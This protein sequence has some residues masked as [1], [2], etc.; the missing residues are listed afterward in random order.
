MDLYLSNVIALTIGSTPA[1]SILCLSFA[2]EGIRTGSIARPPIDG[3]PC[4][5]VP[6]PSSVIGFG[7]CIQPAVG[8]A[9][10]GGAGGVDGAPAGAC[11]AG[12]PIAGAGPV[13]APGAVVVTFFFIMSASSAISAAWRACGGCCERNCL[14][15]WGSNDAMFGACIGVDPYPGDGAVDGPPGGTR[16]CGVPTTFAGGANG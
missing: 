14:E 2:T 1:A 16:G 13:G 15:C 8:P 3:P 6:I 11:G 10:A 7:I 4:G 9:G 5:V 12:A